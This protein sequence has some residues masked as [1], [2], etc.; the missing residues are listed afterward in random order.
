MTTLYTSHFQ[1][2]SA[3]SNSSSHNL[4]FIDMAVED[5][6]DLVNGVFDNTQVF[7]LD[8]THNGVEEITKI[9]TSCN[10]PNLTN[11]HIVCHGAPG[12]LQLGNTHLGLDTLNE[13]SQE[14]RQWQKIFSASA[15]SNNPWNL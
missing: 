1:A 12:Y 11:I 9:L 13:H 7:V 2:N 5:Y 10:R 3:T 4:V 6:S 8:L 15:K 14:L